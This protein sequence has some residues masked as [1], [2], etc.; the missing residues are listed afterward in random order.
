MP[1]AIRIAGARLASRR[2]WSLSRLA[3]RLTDE[4]HRLDDLTVGDQEVRAGINLS[5]ALLPER[6]Q[7]ALRRFGLLGLPHFSAWIAAALE[8]ELDEAEHLLEDLV[9]VSLVEVDRV[10]PVGLV[11][12]QLHDLVRLFAQERAVQEDPPKER[13]AV[14][15]RV[16]G[17]WIWLVERINE[18]VPPVQPAIQAT[19]R[20]S[21]AVDDEIARRSSPGRATG[22]VPRRRS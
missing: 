5:H 10:D 2:Q 3:N 8:T 6:T 13:A 1:L 7:V 15:E 18:T 12:Y 11:R 20:L 16:L 21:R 14:V 17:G 4:Q 9:D 19:F 22:S